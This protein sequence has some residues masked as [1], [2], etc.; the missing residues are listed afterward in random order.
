[1][2]CDEILWLPDCWSKPDHGNRAQR[3]IA[4]EPKQEVGTDKWSD[5]QSCLYLVGQSITNRQFWDAQ[6]QLLLKGQKKSGSLT[7]CTVHMSADDAGSWS[8]EPNTLTKYTSNWHRPNAFQNTNKTKTDEEQAFL[9]IYSST[10]QMYLSSQKCLGDIKSN[11]TVTLL[12]LLF[13]TFFYF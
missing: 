12:L 13:F 4:T 6:E 9:V 8:D 7:N 1:M 11:V 5:V 3:H 10:H 2:G